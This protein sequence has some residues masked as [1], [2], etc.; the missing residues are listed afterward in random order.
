VVIEL[1]CHPRCIAARF[2][3]SGDGTG[4]HPGGGFNKTQILSG[5]VLEVRPHAWRKGCWPSLRA[6]PFRGETG[7]PPSASAGSISGHYSN[8]GITF[9]A[10]AMGRGLVTGGQIGF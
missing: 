2:R 5:E 7:A 10:P 9:H 8:Q 1:D 4:P 6:A 3:R